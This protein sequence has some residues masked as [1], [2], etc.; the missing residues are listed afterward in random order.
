M[1]YQSVTLMTKPV[2]LNMATK[3]G[4]E[5]KMFRQGTGLLQSQDSANE[6]EIAVIRSSIQDYKC[7][8]LGRSGVWH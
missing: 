7:A 1:W 5:K 6:V 2:K 4:K 3:D 8:T